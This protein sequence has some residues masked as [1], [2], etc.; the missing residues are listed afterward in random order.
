ML[1]TS[2]GEHYRSLSVAAVGNE[3]PSSSELGEGDL[4]LFLQQVYS[5]GRFH[6]VSARILVKKRAQPVRRGMPTW[7]WGQL[8]GWTLHSSVFLTGLH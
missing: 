2:Q 7:P 6:T 3:H 5:F 4:R 8:E 1:D